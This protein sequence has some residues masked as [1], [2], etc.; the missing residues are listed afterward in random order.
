ML[1]R[2][3][4]YTTPVSHHHWLPR[5]A[6]RRPLKDISR[7]RAFI[8]TESDARVSLRRTRAR[9]QIP[10]VRTFQRATMRTALILAGRNAA[11]QDIIDTCRTTF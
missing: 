10:R 5:R 7:A 8:A 3:T 1:P 2:S 4:Y 11:R 6:G 9:M